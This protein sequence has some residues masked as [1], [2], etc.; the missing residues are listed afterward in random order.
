MADARALVEAGVPLSLLLDLADP[1]GPDS[2]AIARDERA[3]DAQERT[4]ADLAVLADRAVE[5]IRNARLA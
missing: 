3:D 5:K 1:H 4:L 2:A